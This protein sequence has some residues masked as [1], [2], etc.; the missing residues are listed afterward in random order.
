MYQNLNTRQTLLI[1][2]VRQV[3]GFEPMFESDMHGSMD[4]GCIMH[5]F[6]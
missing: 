3:V 4:A 5:A 6:F 2:F 1:F